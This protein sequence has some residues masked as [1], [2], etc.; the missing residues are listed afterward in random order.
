MLF[1]KG[2][3]DDFSNYR[4]ICLLNHA[5][6]IL[7]AILMR[8]LTK[9]CEKFLSDWQAGFRPARGCRD[10]ILMLRLLYDYVIRGKRDCIV[11]FIDY[12]A[13][14]DSVSHKYIDAIL[15]R[16]GASRKS[17]TIFRS[18]YDAAKGMVRVNGI[19]GQKILSD[20]FD[21]TRG[22]VQ[23]D[24]V[25]PLLFILKLDSLIQNYDKSGSGI[26]IRD[27]QIS[28]YSCAWICR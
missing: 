9:E 2:S 28:N 6:K 24:I 1:K 7:S 3:P 27:K 17:R 21:I 20:I 8:R 16:A 12:K 25:S 5:Y 4:C 22:V 11:T 15:I 26:E 13:A 18:I 23:G 19:L 10:N 14:S